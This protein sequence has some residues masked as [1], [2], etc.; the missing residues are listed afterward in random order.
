MTVIIMLLY[1]NG[2][3]MLLS[4]VCFMLVIALYCTRL[5]KEH[6]VNGPEALT[7]QAQPGNENH[8][9]EEALC[10]P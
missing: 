4:A 8:I 10:V 2:L 9:I 5:L 7:C 6:H 1:E 3:I